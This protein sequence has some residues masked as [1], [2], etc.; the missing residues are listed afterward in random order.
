MTDAD[1][2]NMIIDKS[3]LELLVQVVPKMR[4]VPIEP[5]TH[6]IDAFENF[7]QLLETFVVA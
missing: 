2:L 4:S 7:H 1:N 5:G 6:K 3:G